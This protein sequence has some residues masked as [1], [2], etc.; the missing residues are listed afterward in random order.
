MQREL[1]N[2][3]SD[4]LGVLK[5]CRKGSEFAPITLSVVYEIRKKVATAGVKKLVA[6]LTAGRERSLGV[7]VVEYV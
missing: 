3:W 4:V 7:V 5:K 6:N 2:V 1:A